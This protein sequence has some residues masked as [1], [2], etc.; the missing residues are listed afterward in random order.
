MEMES[1]LVV[2]VPARSPGQN[3]DRPATQTVNAYLQY[4]RS[5]LPP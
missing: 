4:L 5:W 1:V 2:N 3:P